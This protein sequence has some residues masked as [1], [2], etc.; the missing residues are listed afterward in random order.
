MPVA[1]SF[2]NQSITATIY[3]YDSF[4]CWPSDATVVSNTSSNFHC[5]IQQ[6][7]V[8]RLN[9][10]QDKKSKN[11]IVIPSDKKSSYLQEHGT[12]GTIDTLDS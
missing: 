5:S 3:T 11:D 7:M 10:F 8:S 1:Y 2:Y 9:P 4:S 12:D 6:S